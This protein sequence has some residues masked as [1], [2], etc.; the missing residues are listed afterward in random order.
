MS[1]AWT[2]KQFERSMLPIAAVAASP[3]Q[4]PRC[5]GA[6]RMRQI[7]ASAMS[8]METLQTTRSHQEPQ[9]AAVIFPPRLN[10]NAPAASYYSNN[11]AAIASA[12]GLSSAILRDFFLNAE[13]GRDSPTPSAQIEASM[14]LD[15]T[16]AQAALTQSEPRSRPR[17]AQTETNNFSAILSQQQQYQPQQ[18]QQQQLQQEEEVPFLM[19]QED[20]LVDHPPVVQP[21]QASLDLDALLLDIIIPEASYN[22]INHVD[23]QSQALPLLEHDRQEIEL[24][25]ANDN[26]GETLLPAAELPD[27]MTTLA[28]AS[29][30]SEVNSSNRT[31]VPEG[32]LCRRCSAASEAESIASAMLA[33]ALFASANANLELHMGENVPVL[34]KPACKPRRRTGRRRHVNKKKRTRACQM[35]HTKKVPQWRKGPDGT[36]SLC[37]ACGLRWQKQVRMSMQETMQPLGDGTTAVL[38]DDCLDEEADD[39]AEVGNVACQST[40]EQ[41]HMPSEENDS[42]EEDCDA[43]GDDEREF[44]F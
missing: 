31:Y 44:E 33:S 8:G 27:L 6:A 7:F 14:T 40:H 42:E 30:L 3:A 10:L 15:R 38:F 18:R 1:I 11:S 19:E 41:Q 16:W 12:P 23:G 21:S 43:L 9:Q 5:G 2:E 13:L 4:Q 32:P 25:N 29:Q 37:N 26:H 17:P 39:A 34:A 36:A 20:D 28:T 22:T 35:C 24:W